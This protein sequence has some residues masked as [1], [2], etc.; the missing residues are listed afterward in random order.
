M[1]RRCRAALLDYYANDDMRYGTLGVRW[2]V[3]SGVQVIIPEDIEPGDW[4]LS[5]RWDC[6]ESNQYARRLQ[7]HAYLHAHLKNLFAF[8]CLSMIMRRVWSSCSD[9]KIVQQ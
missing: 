6:E 3:W 4:V 8:C 1:R 2:C 7:L 9:V 5:F